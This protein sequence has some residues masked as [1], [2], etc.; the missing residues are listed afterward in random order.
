[1]TRERWWSILLILAVPVAGAAEAPWVGQTVFVKRSG[2]TFGYVENE[3][4][5]SAGEIAELSVPV[6]AQRGDWLLVRSNGR[7][8]WVPMSEVVP[9]AN[10]VEYF[11][12]RIRSEPRSASHYLRRGA[13]W[14]EHGEYEKAASDCSQAIR[15]DP[16]NAAAYYS[17][18]VARHLG[19]LYERALSDYTAA[20]LLAPD[21]VSAHAGRAWLRATCPD[22]RYRD[23]A[24]AVRDALQAC[25]LAGWAD[26]HC[27]DNLAA[28]YAENGQFDYALKWQEKA[29]ELPGLRSSSREY[30]EER[31]KLYKAR[32]P[33]R[34]AGRN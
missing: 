31:V 10:G 16:A 30:A 29:L 18:A 3:K 32:R 22:A 19:K 25:E 20:I 11:T 5:V 26:P 24:A 6:L 27:L 15:L 8:G 7:R 13:V 14:V 33:Y 34:T 12:E 9:L 21:N 17:R 23:G 4:W 1:M 28:A 2:V